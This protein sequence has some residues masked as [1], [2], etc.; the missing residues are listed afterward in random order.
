MRKE[1]NKNKTGGC[2][3]AFRQCFGVLKIQEDAVPENT[4]R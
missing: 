2:K 4:K 1:P 3:L